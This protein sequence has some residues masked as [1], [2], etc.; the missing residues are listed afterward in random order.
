MFAD[1]GI[2]A[3]K[4]T[5][6]RETTEYSCARHRG[7]STKVLRTGFEWH[8]S[9]GKRYSRSQSMARFLHDGIYK[10]SNNLQY[11]FLEPDG[12]MM[13]GNA[14]EILLVMLVT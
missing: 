3:V 5:F 14:Q 9:R 2:A 6:L 1:R 7:F 4:D 13:P 12:M 8:K 10:L 11:W